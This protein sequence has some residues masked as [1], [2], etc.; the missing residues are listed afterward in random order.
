[1]TIVRQFISFVFDTL[2]ENGISAQQALANFAEAK[3]LVHQQKVDLT[4]LVNEKFG[5]S[6]D[7]G[8]KPVPQP[9]AKEG[10]APIAP[11]NNTIAQ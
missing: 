11:A 4:A 5:V 9:V 6:L 10:E 2:A 3:G 7:A 1:M 8:P